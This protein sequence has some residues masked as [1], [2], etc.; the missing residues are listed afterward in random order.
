MLRFRYLRGPERLPTSGARS[1]R[2]WS[3]SGAVSGGP[4]ELLVVVR[5]SRASM[6][7]LTHSGEAPLRSARPRRAHTGEAAQPDR[8]PVKE[9]R[10]REYSP[11]GEEGER[12]ENP[13]R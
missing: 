4:A 12:A 8:M 6:T 13:L 5:R 7:R 11:H 3:F 9:G 10:H 1:P 2:R